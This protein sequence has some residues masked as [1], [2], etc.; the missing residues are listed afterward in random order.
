MKNYF[1]NLFT[2]TWKESEQLSK[3]SIA[4]QKTFSPDIK[5]LVILIYTAIGIS[6]TRYFGNTSDF[7][8][9]ILQN[10]A[11]F[12]MWYCGFF[13][14][15]EIGKFHSMLYWI[16]M[17]ILFYFVIPMIIVKFI[18]KQ[19]LADYGFRLKGIQKDYPL[20]L[21]ML[22]IMLP[23]VFF[24]STTH[25]FQER[26]PLF[27][28]SKGNL[29]PLFLWWQLAY[30]LQFVAVEFFF[31]GFILHGIKNRF[32]FYSI[33][34]MTIP[35]CMVHFG[36]PFGETIAAVFAGI[37]LGTLSLKS[38]SIILGIIIHYSVAIS[39]DVFAL[40]REGYLTF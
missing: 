8:G 39:M 21:L 4:S 5:I 6:I 29:M 17:I 38:R 24:A 26:Y 40:W 14:G 15:S 2:V 22:A 30:F 10:P 31:R 9:P 23:I 11:K 13:F 19:N 35:Y 20:Y 7:L 3:E 37:I 18:F 32:G 16:F 1:F 33:F 36:K 12:S 34:I 28:P 27:Q 25:A